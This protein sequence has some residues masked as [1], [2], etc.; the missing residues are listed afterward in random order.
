MDKKPKQAKKPVYTYTRGKALSD[1]AL[2]LIEKRKK[3][4]EEKERK[5]REREKD[6]RVYMNTHG[7]NVWVIN[8]L[9][10]RQLV[11][12]NN[13]GSE[14][15]LSVL[16]GQMTPDIAL[17]IKNGFLIEAPHCLNP[18]RPYFVGPPP[19][20]DYKDH[21]FYTYYN[22][23]DVLVIVKVL[24]YGEERFARVH[25]EEML[26]VYDQT[27]ET[28]DLHER[29]QK[30]EL[31]RVVGLTEKI[32]IEKWWRKQRRLKKAGKTDGQD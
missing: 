30:G 25:P 8:W 23:S 26:E 1:Q 29:V 27:A 21:N 5:R 13:R 2:D 28:P 3:R 32:K 19:T 20:C 6:D 18:V 31:T 12:V 22:F 10:N 4:W 15:W 14:R 9:G 24:F 17:K 11:G 7:E 16:K